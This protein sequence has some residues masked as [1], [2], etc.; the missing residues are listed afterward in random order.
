LNVRIGRF[1]DAAP[2]G[3][4]C[5]QWVESGHS[6]SGRAE[7]YLLDAMAFPKAIRSA[8]GGDAAFGRDAGAGEDE[9]VADAHRLQHEA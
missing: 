9:D 1:A 8:E 2:F 3:A 4:E 7:A 6:D 5:P